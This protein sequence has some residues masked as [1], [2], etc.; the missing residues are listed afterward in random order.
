MTEVFQVEQH[1]VNDRQILERRT[2][3]LEDGLQVEV[4]SEKFSPKKKSHP[5]SAVLFLPGWASGEGGLSTAEITQELANAAQADAYRITT[6]A[7]QVVPDSLFREAEAIRRLIEDK[8]LKEVTLIGHSQGGSKAIDIAYLLQQLNSDIKVS[9]VLLDSVGLYE[10]GFLELV[11]N[12]IR[13]SMVD[14]T[15][16][17]NKNLLRHPSV[18]LKGLKAGAD[19]AVG[20]GREMARSKLGYAGRFI[21]EIQDMVQEN[22]RAKELQCPVVVIIGA[23]DRAVS[24]ERVASI[25]KHPMYNVY[26][27]ETHRINIEA[28][29]NTSLWRIFPKAASVRFLVPEEFGNHGQPLFR[30]RE[31]AREA[32]KL[33]P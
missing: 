9:V 20:V 23:K 24:H 21:N 33:L 25:K 10:Q 18:Y 22:P 12:F 19:I 13:D 27:L 1:R 26:D 29:R 15:M 8:K 4:S 30:S 32:I 6:R 7:D 28:S 17:M 11:V 31:E 3:T 14:T 16:T 5:D 2:Y